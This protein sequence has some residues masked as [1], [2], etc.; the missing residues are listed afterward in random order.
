MH[1]Y[2]LPD[3]LSKDLNFAYR[4]ISGL[5]DQ[6]SLID[7]LNSFSSIPQN[8][9]SQTGSSNIAPT[10]RI[11]ISNKD[12]FSLL[13]FHALDQIK[14]N[15]DDS[16]IANYYQK[17]HKLI[18]LNPFDE[19]ESQ[20]T[21]S[22]ITR[23]LLAYA[24]NIRDLDAMKI[25]TIYQENIYHPSVKK[26]LK[27]L[28]SDR[29]ELSISN[30]KK[31]SEI[32][33]FLV[34][35]GLGLAYQDQDFINY[36]FNDL[37]S[38]NYQKLILLANKE[39]VIYQQEVPELIESV[40]N[41]LTI[42]R[43]ISEL[44]RDPQQLNILK[45]NGLEISVNHLGL[46]N[47]LSKIKISQANSPKSSSCTSCFTRVFR[48]KENFSDF[49]SKNNPQLSQELEDLITRNDSTSAKSEN[50][51]NF[52]EGINSNRHRN[53]KSDARNPSSIG[54]GESRRLDALMFDPRFIRF[55]SN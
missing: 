42:N 11:S 47:I 23:S 20:P 54:V 40:R 22:G 16:A 14:D 15:R 29:A 7:L 49:L 5:S 53:P 34:N 30:I 2:L 36:K 19:I 44:D 8:I 17:F 18:E 55:S 38:I 12:F 4:S 50:A 33:D 1:S 25:L 3:S 35:S 10:R 46:K 21:R 13:V 27:N 52:I 28:L 39:I 26:E 31:I 51:N 41:L 24:I 45:I 43:E 9:S 6:Q 37:I 48:A 32:F